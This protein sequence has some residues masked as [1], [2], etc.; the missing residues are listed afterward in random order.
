MSPRAVQGIVARAG[1]LMA[2]IRREDPERFDALALGRLE[3]VLRAYD[4]APRSAVTDI[5]TGKRT[6]MDSGK[7]LPAIR[8]GVM[9]D[10]DGHVTYNI[11][12]GR[13]RS[14]GAQRAGATHIRAIVNRDYQSAR[15]KWRFAKPVEI[16]VKL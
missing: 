12:D 4:G 3:Q 9:R 15:G 1:G 6:A 8:I 14:I 5:A 7:T 13:N 2:A 16:V 10:R 11:E